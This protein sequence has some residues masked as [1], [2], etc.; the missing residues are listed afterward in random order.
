MKAIVSQII[1]TSFSSK[2]DGSLGFRGTTPELSTAEK[3]AF[4]ELQGKNCRALFEPMDFVV[5]GKVEIKNPLGTKTPS[6][7]LRGVLFILYKQLSA[8]SKITGSYDEFYVKHMETIIQSYKDQ[9]E[10]ES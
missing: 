1:L 7:R 2:V 9:L 10:P 8:K 3:V 6:E 4:M 5:D